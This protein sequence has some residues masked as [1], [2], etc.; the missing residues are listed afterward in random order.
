IPRPHLARHDVAAPGSRDRRRAHPRGSR[1]RRPRV[2]RHA[3]AHLAAL[4]R[5]AAS[6]ATLPVP[7]RRFTEPLLVDGIDV[8][9]NVL[10]GMTLRLFDD[11]LPRLLAGEW[12]V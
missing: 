1:P 11:V 12:A 10:W 8:E 5:G 4:H 9:G 7:S 6:R 3:P 2:A